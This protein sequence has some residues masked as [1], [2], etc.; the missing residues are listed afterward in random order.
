ML[1][2]GVKIAEFA[3][4]PFL[5]SVDFGITTERGAAVP[6]ASYPIFSN[7]AICASTRPSGLEK[8]CL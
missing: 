8:R 4:G 3:V 7:T 1:S 5:D 6:A 2:E